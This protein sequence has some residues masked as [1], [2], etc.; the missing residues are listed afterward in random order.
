MKVRP[1]FERGFDMSQRFESK[2]ELTEMTGPQRP[3]VL[4]RA[5][6][7]RSLGAAAASGSVTEQ[8]LADVLYL[9]R[10]VAE[11]RKRELEPRVPPAPAYR[12]F[13]L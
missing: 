13:N 12:M 4:R 2:A 3:S 7:P 10:A 9:E 6:R 8:L 11:R 5:P 1:A